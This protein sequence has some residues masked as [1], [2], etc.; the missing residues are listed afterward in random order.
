MPKK[1]KQTDAKCQMVKRIVRNHIVDCPDCWRDYSAVVAPKIVK[2]TP[3]FQMP[4][5]QP[6]APA[7]K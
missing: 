2:E 5:E 1:R 3:P 7:P 4:S 6:A